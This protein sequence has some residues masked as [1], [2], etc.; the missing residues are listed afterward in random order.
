MPAIV[1]SA[2][3][4]VS[5]GTL[6]LVAALV[7]LTSCSVG[8]GGGFESLSGGSGGEDGQGEEGEG[9]EAA[10]EESG[11]P[12]GVMCEFEL[13]ANPIGKGTCVNHVDCCPFPRV[14]DGL[15]GDAGC[16]ST[17][18]PNN[19]ECVEG[20]CVQWGCVGNED[21]KQL[22]GNSWTCA[23]ISGVGHCVVGCTD[24]SDCVTEN[25]PLATCE[26]VGSYDFCVQPQP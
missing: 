7:V 9:Q 13:G 24:D 26:S 11:F 4:A 8:P 23:Q 1:N 3:S 20:E 2:N 21:C 14:G 25:L 5:N 17:K 16:P 6:A 10:D 12:P 19:W 15:V 22:M 18:F